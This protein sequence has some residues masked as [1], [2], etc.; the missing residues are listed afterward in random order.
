[1][2]ICTIL[3]EKVDS[4]KNGTDCEFNGYLE[5]YLNLGTELEPVLNDALTKILAIEPDAKICVNLKSEI[6]QNAISNQ[7]IRYKD[8]F[9]LSGKAMDYPYLVYADH[10]GE[11]RALLLIPNAPYSFIYAKGCY[12]CMT[13]PGSPFIDCKNEIVAVSSDKADVIVDTWE[14]M[15]KMKA[16]ALQRSIDRRFFATYDDL[17]ADAVKA[18]AELKEE[19]PEKLAAI[20]GEERQAEIYQY[21]IKWFLLKKVLYVQYMVNKNILNSVH[22]G[23]VK[24]QRNQAKLNADEIS[25][26]SFS[27]MWRMTREQADHMQEAEKREETPEEVKEEN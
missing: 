26:L 15:F 19:A 20:S 27:E 7:I 12:Y 17:K 6:S 1:M 11:Q 16:G 18:A 14:K 5:D 22:E 9:K 21:V 8:I 23:N 24:K 2:A 3:D 10:E 25:F 13:E 4:R